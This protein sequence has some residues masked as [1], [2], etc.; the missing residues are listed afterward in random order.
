MRGVLGRMRLGLAVVVCV[1][2]L[3]A[4][5]DSGLPDRNLPLEEARNR[6]FPFPAYE[7]LASNPPVAAGGRH[8]VRSAAAETIPANRLEPVASAGGTQLYAVRGSR[9]PYSRL[10]APAGQQNRWYPFLPIN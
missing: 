10:Y 2:G 6:V 9:A 4:C 5:K 1:A 8:W 7:P 3:T